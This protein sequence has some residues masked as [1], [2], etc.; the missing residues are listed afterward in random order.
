[1][2]NVDYIDLVPDR[3][4]L[5]FKIPIKKLNSPLFL[6]FEYKKVTDINFTA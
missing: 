3:I 1:M 5:Y 2:R 6:N 4:P